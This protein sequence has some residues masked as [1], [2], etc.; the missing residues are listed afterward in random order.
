MLTEGD[1][2]VGRGLHRKEL[3]GSHVGAIEPSERAPGVYVFTGG[4]HVALGGVGGGQTV[5]GFGVGRGDLASLNESRLEY[6]ADDED[7]WLC[8]PV[9][10][11][12]MVRI[13]SE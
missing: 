8:D 5:H 11:L 2:E 12:S 6:E 13:P 1:G 9:H 10:D 7:E 3:A 4:A